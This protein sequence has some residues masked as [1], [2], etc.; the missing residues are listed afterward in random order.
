MRQP[1]RSFMFLVGVGLVAIGLKILLIGNHLPPGFSEPRSPKVFLLLLYLGVGSGFIWEGLFGSQSHPIAVKP[2]FG[3]AIL[4]KLS[5][6]PLVCF[7]VLIAYAGYAWFQV[8]HWPYYAHPDPKELPHRVLLY[9]TGI[10]FLVGIFSILLVPVG[11]LV[12]RVIS[13]RRNYA[14][15]PLQRATVLYLAGAALWLL[16]LAAVHTAM[17]WTSTIGWSID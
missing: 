10:F 15:S 2:T 8:G 1:Y 7:G 9:I 13:A 4:R 6:L 14:S 5:L 16:D 17:P 11:L 3:W 12:G